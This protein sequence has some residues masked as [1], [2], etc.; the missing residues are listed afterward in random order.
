MRSFGDTESIFTNMDVLNPNEEAY[1]P[2]DL[3]ERE[4]EL[5]EIHSALRPLT[6]G[7]TPINVLIYGETGQ[8]K[9]VAVDL[10]T[11]ELQAWAEEEDVDLTVLTVQC[12]GYNKSYHAM[13]YLVKR[14]REER[15]GP[16]EETPKG[17]Q[18]KELFLQMRQELEAIGGTV[19]VVLDEIDS[20]G[21]DDYILYELPRATFDNVKL[22]V[23]GITNDLTYRDN[24]D[25]DVRSSLG[26]DEIVFA[27]YNASQLMNILARRAAGSLRD[28]GFSCADC[29]RPDCPHDVDE[30]AEN[31]VSDVIEQ[32]DGVIEL[33]AA[34]AAQE[35]GDAR[36][37][38]QILYRAARFVDDRADEVITAADIRE[39][40]A[41]L[42]EKAVVSGIQ[43]LPVQKRLALLAVTHEAAM[44]AVPAGTTALYDRYKDYSAT[45]DT[46][47][48]SRRRFRD[49]LNDLCHQGLLSRELGG[50]GQGQENRYMLDV[51][52][53][54]IVNHLPE[55]DSRLDEIVAEIHEAAGS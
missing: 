34:L 51:Q 31:L 40:Q 20:L 52:Y 39:A 5:N 12:K 14:L 33:A 43:T 50:R 9:T 18:I 30:R 10:K 2:R 3:P 22:S 28:T 38:L 8:G 42:E 29:A 26:E 13:A 21:E 15:F 41:Y 24:L 55:E 7:A 44:N 27:P 16:G 36:L 6:L 48:V 25:S 49:L 45:I 35:T 37:A 32:D 47:A 1:R 46:G 23:I 54:M 11:D 4:Q 17:Y 19:I 53:Q